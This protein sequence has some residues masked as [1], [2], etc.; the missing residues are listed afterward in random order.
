MHLNRINNIYD[1]H[2]SLYFKI[3]SHVNKYTSRIVSPQLYLTFT[4]K[5]ILIIFKNT[6]N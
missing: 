1:R 6:N 5:L 3:S 4:S 2:G